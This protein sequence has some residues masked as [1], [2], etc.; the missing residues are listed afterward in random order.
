MGI[1]KNKFFIIGNILLLLAV[2]PITLYVVKRQ[3]DLRS[4]AAPS[5]VLS[6]SPASASTT[7]GQTVKLDVMVNPGQNIVSIVEMTIQVDPDKFDIVSLERNATAFS[8]LLKGP[9]I[10][11]DGTAYLSIST[12]TEISKAIQSTTKA[13]TLTLKAKAPTNG[14][15]SIVKFSKSPQTDVL[16]LGT[17]DG[18]TENVLSSTDVAS[19]TVT[20]GGQVGVSPAPSTPNPICVSLTIDKPSS[21]TLPYSLTFTG[22][23]SSST[24]TISKVS[25]NFGDGTSQDVTSGGGIGTNTVNTQ[26][27]HTYSN[28][29]TFTANAIFTDNANAI[30]DIGA[31]TTSITI[32]GQITPIATD[33]AQASPSA[34]PTIL[35]QAPT[36]SPTPTIP[37][38]TP[39]LPIT[40]TLQTTLTILGVAGATIG[41]GLLLFIL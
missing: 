25:F 2:I 26:I 34:T 19:I 31:C 33:S 41:V 9:T 20:G 3:T 18:A 29:G 8:S 10:N 21:G 17:S 35:A 16:S 14:A 7:V 36:E 39:T 30:S 22:A 15:P 32:A 24:G 5:T 4:K 37:E 27:A 6:F 11:K 23:G 28:P 1:L 12:S 40:G 13:A 38:A